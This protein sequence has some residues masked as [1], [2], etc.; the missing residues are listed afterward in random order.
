MHTDL[1]YAYFIVIIAV[2]ER[3]EHLTKMKAN[4]YLS[5]YKVY[6]KHEISLIFGLN[7]LFEFMV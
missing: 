3:I 1:V 2:L 6:L 7:L 4:I 5:T